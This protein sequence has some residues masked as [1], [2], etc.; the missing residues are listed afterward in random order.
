M[1]IR[2]EFMN[3]SIGTG[4]LGLYTML[5]G[6]MQHHV[7][8]YQH[9][10]WL[11]RDGITLAQS[12][13]DF[14]DVHRNNPYVVQYGKAALVKAVLEAERKSKLFVDPRVEGAVFDPA[15]LADTWFV[16]FMHMLGRGIPRE[17]ARQIFDRV[18]FVIFNYDRCV[19][20]FLENALQRLFGIN[21]HDAREIVSDLHIIHPYGV[22]GNVGFGHG[23]GDYVALAGQIKTYTEQLANAD[24]LAQVRDEVQRA[25]CI[26]FLGFAYH[27]Q[28]LLMLKPEPSVPHKYVF[29][30]AHGM[31]DADVQVVSNNI[32]GFFTPSMNTT[33]RSNRIKIE[34]KLKCA[35]LFDNYARSLSGGD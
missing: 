24:I 35:Q 18:S 32:A 10:A 17:N 13:D 4:D 9:A 30:T 11:I 28:N 7:Q 5:T 34:N 23:R 1:D 26:V 8:E 22:V 12:I 2:F 15:K 6:Q 33:Q 25:E 29:G 3:K 21:E 14:I 27:R 16:K 20:Y 19:E 31:S